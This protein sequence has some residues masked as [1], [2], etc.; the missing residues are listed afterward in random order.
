MKTQTFLVALFCTLLPLSMANASE[1]SFSKAKKM[2][3]TKV[4]DNQ[5]ETF[6]VGCSWKR[7]KVNLES[8]GLEHAF[9]KKMMKRAKRIEAEHIIPSSWLYKVNGKL[10]QCAIEAKRL[11]RSK[12]KYCRRHDDNFKRAHNDLV[13]LRVAVG[14]LN[15][16]RSNK[17]FF[18]RC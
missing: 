5:G 15:A 17:P 9:P 7:K 18:K 10:R 6:Y 16:E 12:R 13:N 2:L 3:Y 14:A 11:Q 1:N 8:C 4:Y